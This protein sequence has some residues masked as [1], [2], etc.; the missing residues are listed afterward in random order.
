MERSNEE[1]MHGEG[2]GGTEGR[3]F[4]DAAIRWGEQSERVTNV[5]EGEQMEGGGHQMET[6]LGNWTEGLT[7]WR[8]RGMIGRAMG[9]LER[10]DRTSQDQ[11]IE[12]EE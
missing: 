10:V 6:V 7:G 11:I 5:E 9:G 4:E 12:T 2:S 1:L 3:Q 8:E